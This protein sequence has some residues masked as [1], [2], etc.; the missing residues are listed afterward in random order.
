MSKTVDQQ[1][2]AL[3]GTPGTGVARL[4]NVGLALGAMKQIIA[5]T[6]QMP[7]IAALSGPAGYGKTQA[8]IYMAH[9]MGMNAAFVQLRPFETMKSLAAL[10]LTELDVRWKPHWP[11]ATMFDAICERLQQV[12]R[13][14]VIDEVDHIAETKS[15]DFIRAVHD[16][17][18]TPIF[19]IG[20]ERLQAK[21][22]SRHERFHDRVLVWVNAVAADA[23]DTRA[24]AAHYAPAL[25]WADGAVEA[26][27]TKTHGVA[28]RITTEVE[29]LKEDA[30][31]HGVDTV[32]PDLV[33]VAAKGGRRGA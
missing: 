6:P 25:K 20:E 1:P 23:S 3:Q 33:G 11:V 24:L 2:G 10:L 12:G 18:A 8:A 17:C 9:P 28:R 5:A 14:L 29:R 15:I 32:T 7:R 13:P 16:K 22:L 26:L 30:R 21:L 27:L 31:R 19:L 4:T